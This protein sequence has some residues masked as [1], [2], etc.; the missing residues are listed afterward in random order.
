MFFKHINACVSLEPIGGAKPKFAQKTNGLI[1]VQ[2][3]GNAISLSCPAQGSPIPSFRLVSHKYTI[4]KSFL[5]PI[6][7]AGPKFAH[8]SKGS[9]LL[10][11]FGQTISLSCPAQGFPVPS[12]RFV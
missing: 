11:E 6:G 8:E 10:K 12:F 2:K 5:E 9:I 1:D 4:L 7:G 3:S